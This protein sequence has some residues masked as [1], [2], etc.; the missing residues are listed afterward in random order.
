MKF[1]FGLDLLNEICDA[2]GLP[3]EVRS[4]SIRA[5]C[6]NA[7]I[8]ETEQV[9]TDE[10]AGT[11]MS[12]LRRYQLV[13]KFEGRQMKSG[14]SGDADVTTHGDVSKGLRRLVNLETGY[15]RFEKIEPEPDE[16]I[17]VERKES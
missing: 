17:I 5:D 2:F 11:L 10:Q 14:P 13:E 7:V 9:M 1:V 15:V 3:K 6:E 12:I 16:P 4:I 8:F